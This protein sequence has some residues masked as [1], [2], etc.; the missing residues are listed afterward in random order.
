MNRYQ[1]IKFEKFHKGET[2]DLYAEP[3]FYT[4]LSN[5]AID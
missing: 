2:Q 4:A 3:A 5:I 1:K